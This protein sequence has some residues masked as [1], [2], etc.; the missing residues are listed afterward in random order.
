MTVYADYEYYTDKY[1][2]GRS[3]AV[4]AA[5]FN[6]YAMQ[7]STVI[8]RYTFGNVDAENVPEAVQSCCCELAEMICA[9]KTSQAAQKAGIS[10][11]SVQ[12]W[13]QS[14]ASASGRHTAY[15]CAQRECIHRWL[16]N[17]GL[18]YS[19]VR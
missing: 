7:A 17:T 4:K 16:S 1:L 6:F 2:Y 8:D 14:Y 11:E 18:L 19:G 13:S 9:E 3:A 12:G 5:D 15:L 10:S